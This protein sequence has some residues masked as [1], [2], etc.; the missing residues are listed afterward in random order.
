MRD[1]GFGQMSKKAQNLNRKQKGRCALCD[2]TF[3]QGDVMEIDHIQPRVM[4]GG[5]TYDNLRLVHG[6]C[7]DQRYDLDAKRKE[8]SK[9][10]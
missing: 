8:M 7:H 4:G 3:E 10:S 2:L 6:H 9:E 1:Y 5:D